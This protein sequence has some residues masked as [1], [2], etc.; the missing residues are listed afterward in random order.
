MR[1]VIPSD[2]V[3]VQQIEETSE[4]DPSQWKDFKLPYDIE[5]DQLFITTQQTQL[6]NVVK[7]D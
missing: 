2:D 5:N 4:H 7:V 1:I 3:T 6:P